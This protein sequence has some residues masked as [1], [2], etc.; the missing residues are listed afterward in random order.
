MLTIKATLTCDQ[1]SCVASTEVTLKLHEDR[2]MDGAL[3]DHY[4]IF[5]DVLEVPEGWVCNIKKKYYKCLCPDCNKLSV[6][7]KY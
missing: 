7:V 1:K 5:M 4:P 3:S 2:I 6:S